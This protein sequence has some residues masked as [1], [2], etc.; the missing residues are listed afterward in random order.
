[1][2]YV[3]P[4]RKECL[5]ISFRSKIQT[6]RVHLVIKMT[7]LPGGTWQYSLRRGD[8]CRPQSADKETEAK[9]S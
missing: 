4:G 9:N 1:M 3:L 6:F 8:S 7:T 2:I 5:G